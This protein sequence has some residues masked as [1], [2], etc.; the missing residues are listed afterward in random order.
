M[1]TRRP[2]RDRPSLCRREFEQLCEIPSA[3]CRSI[4]QSMRA[5]LPNDAIAVRDSIVHRAE[6][7]DATGRRR[8]LPLRGAHMAPVHDISGWMHLI[9]LDG[10]RN[11]D[12]HAHSRLPRARVLSSSGANSELSPIP[13]SLMKDDPFMS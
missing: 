3:L 1:A 6:V 11:F 2:E 5:K 9:F 12:A 10:L 13:V 4:K 8:G 7:V